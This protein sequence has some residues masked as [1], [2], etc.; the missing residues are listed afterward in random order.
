MM[1]V[2]QF[3]YLHR[4][5]AKNS[6]ARVVHPFS[7]CRSQVNPSFSNKGS[8]KLLDVNK[9]SSLTKCIYVGNRGILVRSEQVIL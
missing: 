3:G 9:M 1:K 6:N 7:E 5:K 2:L 4:C 8:N